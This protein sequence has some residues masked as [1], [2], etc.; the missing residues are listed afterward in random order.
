M[1]TSGH[2]A[3]EAGQAINVDGAARE[4]RSAETGL[5]NISRLSLEDLAQL[6][7]SVVADVLQDLIERRRCGTRL[8]DRYS[9]HNSTV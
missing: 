7:D 8:G 9:N 3:D 1:P 2:E 4:V 5:L 6:D